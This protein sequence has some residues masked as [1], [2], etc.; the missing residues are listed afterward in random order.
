MG[1]GSCT[2]IA[3]GT[4]VEDVI[5]A[6]QSNESNKA[7]ARLNLADQILATQSMQ[8]TTENATKFLGYENSTYG[9][10]MQYPSDWQSVRGLAIHPS[11]NA[12]V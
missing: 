7:L 12:R 5:Q 8:T 4:L 9:I 3:N 2:V 10:K 11:Y 6:L 1:N